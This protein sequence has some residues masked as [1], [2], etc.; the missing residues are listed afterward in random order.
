MKVL[1]IIALSIAIIG[2]G[3]G[4]YVQF[5]IVP[6]EAYMDALE[7]PSEIERRLWIHYHEQMV[8]FGV[9][10]M[11][12]GGLGFLLGLFPAFKTKK[13]IAW[14]SIVIGLAAFFL[15]ASQGTHLFS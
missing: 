5:E 13:P 4:L 12:L 14:I 7:N 10:A 3:L 15:G 6:N 9:I 11:A 1:S 8:N 2:L